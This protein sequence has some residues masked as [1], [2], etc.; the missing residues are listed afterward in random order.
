VVL[1]LVLLH[2]GAH[3]CLGLHE[4]TK[5]VEVLVVATLLGDVKAFVSHENA[6]STRQD[7]V[8]MMTID[9]C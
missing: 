4:D 7:N 2:G 5:A 8:I 9:T 6:T 1:A 3:V